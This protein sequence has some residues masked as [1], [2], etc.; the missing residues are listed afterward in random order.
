[1]TLRGSIIVTLF[2]LV[3]VTAWAQSPL[4]QS[5]E[6]DTGKQGDELVVSGQSLDKDHVADL[7]LTAGGKDIK[8]KMV[9]QSAESIR[10]S[11][12]KVRPGRYK[13]MILT[14][15][16]EPHLPRAAGSLSLNRSI[17]HSACSLTGSRA[18]RCCPWRQRRCGES[19]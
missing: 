13:L 19:R 8:V 15:G 14:R 3:A 11:V 6:P 17:A 10:F 12:P 9:E 4:V 1:M 5:V 7:F 16:S 2:A 18:C